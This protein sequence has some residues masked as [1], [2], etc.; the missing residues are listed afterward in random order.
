MRYLLAMVGPM[1]YRSA[2]R[3]NVP[4]CTIRYN[5][6]NLPKGNYSHASN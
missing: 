2:T 5:V 6:T 4:Q 3:R 1:I